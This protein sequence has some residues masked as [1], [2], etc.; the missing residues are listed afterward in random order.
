[1][2]R[3]A[4]GTVQLG[5]SYGIANSAGV[6]SEACA[7]SI[8]DA[9]VEMGISDFDTAKAYGKSES[10]I[11]SWSRRHD[12]RIVSKYS[13]CGSSA[14]ISEKLRTSAL[15]TLAKLG[16]ERMYG[17]LLHNEELINDG[18]WMQGLSSLKDAGIVQKVGISIYDPSHAMIAARSPDIDIIQIPYSVMDQRLDECGFFEVAR[19]F[20]K[21]VWARSAFVQGLLFLESQKVPS[22]LKEMCSLR[23][24]AGSIGVEHGYTMQQLAILFSLGNSGIDRV[25]IGVDNLEQLMEYK[26]IEGRVSEYLDCRQALVK[27]LRGK[28]D[29]YLVSPHKWR[30]A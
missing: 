4:L 2:S 29:P 22:N 26:G 3:L 27:A 5:I 15:E 13:D 18:A 16:C 8:L 23:E 30:Q 17:Y 6:P 11:G 19:R 14:S 21:E 12:V 24:I 1:M 10:V 20:G 25:L 9:A 28:V 7:H